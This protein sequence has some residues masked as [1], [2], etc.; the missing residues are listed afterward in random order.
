MWLLEGFTKAVDNE[1]IYVLV[2]IDRYIEVSKEIDDKLIG[3]KIKECETHFIDRV[4]GQHAHDD[5]PKKGMKRG[6]DIEKIKETLINPNTKIVKRIINN[7]ER[8]QYRSNNVKVS[9]D[10]KRG[11]LIQASQR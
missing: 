10:V 8:N 2:G 4:I 5:I 1:D 9:L 6:V 3:I 11:R 7:E